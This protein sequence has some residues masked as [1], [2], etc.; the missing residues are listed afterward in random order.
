V[1]GRCA[2]RLSLLA[3]LAAGA[4]TL[5]TSS[6]LG[7]WSG[8]GQGI[9]NAFVTTIL[10]PILTATPVV[11]GAQ[12]RWSEVA[13]PQAGVP[14]TYFIRRDGGAPSAGCPSESA[15]STVLSCTDTGLAGGS[16]HTYVLV[17]RWRSWGAESE[18]QSVTAGTATAATHFRLEAAKQEVGAG[19][20]DALTITALDAANAPATGYSG[21]HALT[22][23]GA[24]GAENG[25]APTVSSEAGAAV[26]FGAATAV[27][28]TEGKAVV[29][30]ASNGL[31]R[32]YK[33][34]EAHIKVSEGSLNNEAAL[35]AVKVKPGVFK[36][37]GVA[38]S[39]AEPS[40]GQAFEVKL[41][42]Y[43]EWHNTVTSFTRTGKLRY[44]G[45]ESSPSGKAPEYSTTT[46]PT[47]AGGQATVTGFKF[48]KAAATT[49]KVTEEG[50][51]NTGSATFTVKPGAAAS[52][53]LAAPNP[54]EPETGQAVSVT[55][56]A[57]DSFGNTATSFGGSA[58]EAKTL[59]YTG[60]EASPSGKAPEYPASATTVTFT[61]G[62]GMATGI[63]LYKAAVTILKA[64]DVGSG[65]TGSVTFTVKAPV[66]ATHFRLEAAK[67][68]VGAGEADALTIT[69][70]TAA[71]GT[72]TSYSG[73]H[74]LTF[75]GA[76]SAASG[77]APTVT[78][79]AGAAVAFGAATAVRF[80][81]GKAVVSGTSNG[82]MR[83]YRV[84][85]AHIEVAEGSLN[86]E[87][88]LLAI[89]VKPGAFKS[90]ALTPSPGEPQV[91]VAFEVKLTAWDEWHNTV[92]SYTRTGKLRYEGAENSPS[93]MAPEYSTNVEPTFAGGQATVTGFKFYKAAATTLKV[94]EEGSGNTGSATFTVKP[95]PASSLTATT[96]HLAWEH[97]TTAVGTLTSLCLFTCE[98]SELER[99]DTFKA[100]VALTDQFGNVV[101]NLGAGHEVHVK[102]T[103]KGRGSSTP[104]ELIIP[105]EGPAESAGEVAFTTPPHGGGT[106]T[107][108]A[109]P[110]T[111]TAFNSALAKLHF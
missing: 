76:S 78:S 105:A 32:L 88:A 64:T 97:P 13:S 54:A 100:H 66:P 41:T 85:E 11:E 90:F 42:A 48:Y 106:A 71:N 111:G 59:S 16:R 5:S 77:T 68:E 86:N 31:M 79:E 39:P 34:E 103:S 38:P 60:P 53:K 3:T 1:R 109:A 96:G 19:E 81:E 80:T 51:G 35:L 84:E 94:T 110:A 30:G 62:V 95:E 67:Q 104:G 45:A 27:K 56:T 7:Y 101:E 82:L 18:V 61:Q 87:G 93:G 57:L 50:S 25:T 63:K 70:L 22:F 8:S 58:G 10:P 91:G 40:T 83:L 74:A 46:E 44:E 92:T 99:G 6:A 107:L 102:L 28:F 72:A 43:D 17:A 49:L 47:F 65:D 75:S 26:A 12:L 2:I 15:P 4:L 29:S 98:D 73:S 55:M 108:T 52:L 9:G 33:A 89:K 37:F 24:A 69:A 36:S 20:A 14:V 23:S 21:T